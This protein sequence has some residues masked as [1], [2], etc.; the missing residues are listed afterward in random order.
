MLRW[1]HKSSVKEQAS[2]ENDLVGC[3]GK[4]PLDAEFI[5]HGVVS[6]ELAAMEQWYQDAFR[7][8]RRHY[9]ENLKKLFSQMP[10]QRFLIKGKDSCKPIVGSL[11]ASRDKSGRAYPFVIFRVLEHPLAYQFPHL[12]PYMYKDFF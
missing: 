7:S 1:F 8:L 6:P 3:M 10:T 9:G 11:I 5:K 2:Y 4:L 12:I